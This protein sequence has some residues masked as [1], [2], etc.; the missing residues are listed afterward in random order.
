MG[1]DLLPIVFASLAIGLAAGFVM[2]R[3]DFCVT[4]SFRDMFLFRDFFLMRQ[5]VL[6]V[7]VSM[8]LFESGRLA[9]LIPGQSFPLLGTPT[10][11]SVAGG[12][13]FGIGMVLAGGCVVGSLYKMGAGSAAGAL[14]FTGML[15]GSA[16]Y[17]EIHPQ[18]SAFARATVH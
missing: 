9:G 18:W 10:L 14:V 17:A 13:V 7:V 5:M 6:L 1:Q 12:F 11:A 8:V 3:A 4:A 2:H 16:A 15:A